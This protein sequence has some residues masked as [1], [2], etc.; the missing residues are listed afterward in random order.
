[1]DTQV[2][3]LA[4]AEVVSVAP[5]QSLDAAICIMEQ[6]TIHHLPVISNGQLVGMISDR[7][8]LLAVGWRLASERMA[9]DSTDGVAGPHNVESI[10]TRP[11][12]TLAPGD[13][14]S[15]AARTM[16]DRQ[17]GAMPIVHDGQ[18]VGILTE[19]DLLRGLV[20][21][22][23][24]SDAA[25]RLLRETVRQH[26]HVS[27]ISVRPKDSLMDVLNLFREKRLRHVPVVVEGLSGTDTLIGIVSDR[28]AR[29]ALGESAVRDEQAQQRG[30]FYLGPTAV[31]EVMSSPV[32]TTTPAATIRTVIDELLS[33]RIHALPV[34]A[35]G[36]LIGIITESDIVRAIGAASAK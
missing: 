6:R 14:V 29:R 1:M 3:A 32:R 24:A 26:M 10:M 21:G 35:D 13:P 16:M 15:K 17:I 28:D 30:D 19:A 23:M 31:M 34:V 22:V 7:D 9:S 33:H 18:V 20:E 2:S 12:L 25:R 27:A 8:L 36:T 5:H 4:T 11:V